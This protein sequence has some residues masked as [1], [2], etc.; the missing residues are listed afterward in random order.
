MNHT[1]YTIGYSGYHQNTERFVSDLKAHG[2]NAIVDV[3]TSPYSRYSP[4][5]NRETIS[6]ILKASGIHYLFMGDKL[7][8]RPNDT[9]C[10][11]NGA[12]DY[13]KILE[14]KCFRD[15]I[16]RVV[17][18]AQKGYLISLMCAEKDPICCHRNIL[19]AHALASQGIVIKHFVQPADGGPAVYI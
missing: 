2:I 4:E 10:Y 17:D 12:V 15:G 1:V 13:D 6:A 7:G 3:R 5:Y 16:N 14:S 19:V 8:A 18:G 11:V 9:S